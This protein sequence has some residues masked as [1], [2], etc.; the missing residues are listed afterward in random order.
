MSVSLNEQE[1][2]IN[3]FPASV[4]DKA[5]IF[6]CVPYM[7]TRLRKLAAEYPQEVELREE[8]ECIFCTLP[9]SWIRISPK[10]KCT[11]SE[12]QKQ[13]N[14]ERLRKYMEAKKT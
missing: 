2:T 8:S 4:S 9:Y 11:L 14:A 5:E 7:M 12:E 1:T 13:A 3:M 10:R 6:T